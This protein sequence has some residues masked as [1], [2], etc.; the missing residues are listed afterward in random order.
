MYV[1]LKHKQSARG[2]EHSSDC[3]WSFTNVSFLLNAV[4]VIVLSVLF[5]FS[6]CCGPQ[7]HSRKISFVILPEHIASL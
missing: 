5:A 3:K 1:L 2:L 7:G 4:N 6:L